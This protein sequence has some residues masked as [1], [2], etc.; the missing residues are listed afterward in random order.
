MTALQIACDLAGKYG[1]ELHLVHTTQP[2][3]VAFALGAIP[4]YHAV[5]TM[6]S[7][8]EVQEADSK[9]IEE[10]VE[11]VKTNGHSITSTHCTEGN[12]VDEVLDCAESTGADLIVTGRK[13]VGQSRCLGPR[14]HISHRAKCAHLSVT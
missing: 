1:S 9:I 12:P 3:T 8:A 6:P 7:A 5:T 11:V 14:Q 13:G 10:G 4:G 2:Q